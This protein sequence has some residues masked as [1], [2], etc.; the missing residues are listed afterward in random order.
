ME[1]GTLVEDGNAPDGFGEAAKFPSVD[2]RTCIAVVEDE[3][4]LEVPAESTEL[5]RFDD[6]ACVLEPNPSVEGKIILELPAEAT[7]LPIDVD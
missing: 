7:E 4:R 6:L 5:P 2:D 3:I 1:L